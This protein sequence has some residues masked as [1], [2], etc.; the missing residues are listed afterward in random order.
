MYNVVR[1]SNFG[2]DNKET[3]LHSLIAPCALKWRKTPQKSDQRL[4]MQSFGGEA[5]DGL[6]QDWWALVEGGGLAPPQ[7]HTPA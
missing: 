3:H 5:M 6:A 7:T 4:R 1:V 2:C